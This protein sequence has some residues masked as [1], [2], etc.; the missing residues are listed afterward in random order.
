MPRK[1]QRPFPRITLEEA[2]KVPRALKEFNGGNPWQPSE[3]AQAL[4]F[5]ATASKFFYVTSASRGYGFTEG[6]RDA[7]EIS[8][9][10]L[11]RQIA[12]PD[13]AATEAHALHEGFRNV[14]A[15]ASVLDYFS[16]SE[17]PEKRYLENT[18]QTEFNLE[19]DWHDEFLDTFRANCKYI[20]IG[21]NYS[22]DSYSSNEEPPSTKSQA[23]TNGVTA[24]VPKEGAPVCFVVMPF[25]ERGDRYEAGFFDE[26]LRSLHTPALESTGFEVRTAQRGGSDVIQATI[27]NELLNAEL[28]LVDL[29]D[30]NPNVLFELGVRIAEK[31]PI[32]LVKARGTGRVFDV[33][34]MLRCAEYSPNLWA[35]TLEADVPAIAEH[36]RAAWEGR[37]T[38]PP[39]MSVLRSQSLG[40]G[41][42]PQTS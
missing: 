29:T 13:S 35:S 31:K 27:L 26:V 23:A 8:L 6:T 33:D 15:F 22:K 25:V 1:R 4:G 12:Y 32:A 36:V 37:N 10:D 3:L 2:A 41:L 28:A 42:Q 18:L 7:S 24:I 17:L 19:P 11:G 30:H 39:L 9:T 34:N 5:S 38:D 14:D 16:G 21:S 40:V 20:G